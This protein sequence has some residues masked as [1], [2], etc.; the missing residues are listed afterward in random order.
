MAT[1]YT[2]SFPGS[3]SGLAVQVY[4]A[5]GDTVGS[6]STVGNSAEAWS[7]AT[8]SVAL[9]YDA[10]GYTATV[11]D[12]H[13]IDIATAPGV[14]NVEAA[15]GGLPAVAAFV[16]DADDTDAASVALAVDAIR[17]ALIAAGLMAAS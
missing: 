15:V 9:T 12:E 11:T 3:C 1:T 6:A 14:I 10:D 17:D 7:A 13:G 5:A 8:Y 4:D 16:D 2:F